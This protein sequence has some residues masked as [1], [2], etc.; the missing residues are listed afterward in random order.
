MTQQNN[1]TN[2]NAQSFE[3]LKNLRTA[4]LKNATDFQQTISE[5]K[6]RLDNIT[7]SISA[8]RSQYE[9]E[10]ANKQYLEMQQ[11]EEQANASVEASPVSD[12][13][14]P[15]QISADTPEIKAPESVAAVKAEEKVVEKVVE[16]VQPTND[17]EPVKK[18]EPKKVTVKVE[19]KTQV[20][21]KP[22]AP[23]ATVEKQ[24][25]TKT[26]ATNNT[27]KPAANTSSVANAQATSPNATSAPQQKT[28]TDD[29]GNI[30]VRRFLEPTPRPAPRPVQQPNNN[31]YNNNGQRPPYQGS[32]AA[33][34]TS[35]R[36]DY[37]RTRPPYQ[38]NANGAPRRPYD[39]DADNST[40]RPTGTKPPIKKTFA[41]PAVLPSTT[42]EK[43][44]GNKNKT[45]EKA[46]DKKAQNKRS[47]ITKAY[48]GLDEEDERMIARRPRPTKKQDV[49]FEP[50]IKKIEKATVN[51]QEVPIKVFSEK[52]GV[53]VTEIIKQLFK[54]GI[55]KTIN[56]SIDYEYAAFIASN[57]K[58]ELEL[59][60]DKTAED[61]VTANVDDDNLPD[62]TKRPPI[63]TVMG[64]VD[65]GKT[66]LLDA[67]RKAHVT[68]GEAGGITQHIGAYMV[69]IKNE[70]ITFIDTPGHAAFTAMRARGAKVTDVAIIVVAADDGVMPQTIEAINHAKAAE[71]SIIVAI[72]KMDKTDTNPERVKQQLAEL[73]LVPEE[74]GGDTIMVP[75]SAKTKMGIDTLL[76]SV[77]LVTEIKELKANPKKKGS[78]TVIEASLDKGRGPVATILVRNGT[79]RVGDN[80]IAGVATGK[81]RAMFDDK[82]KKVK[83]AKP[84]Y[85]VEVLG[86][87]EVPNAG[88]FMYVAD[89]KLVKKMAEERKTKVKIE[90][91]KATPAVSLGDIFG[92][93]SEGQLKS[94]NLIIKTDVQG[95]LE[96]LKLSLTKIG[97]EEVKINAI[98]GGVGAI[99]E[100]DVM[101]ARASDAIIIGFNVRADANAKTVA[102]RE[103]VDI[104]TYN[105]IYDA[106]DDVTKAMKGMLEP[107]FKETILGQV[108]VRDVFRIT[109]VGSVAG[110]YVNSGK[111]TRSSK[112]R[113]YRNDVVVF[114]G[115]VA[116]LKRFKDDAKEV[117]AGFECGVS[118][119]NY[120]DIKVDDVFEPYIMEEIQQ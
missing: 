65:H 31:R 29:K 99:N 116:A 89:E 80:V 30:K 81:I 92:R 27:A 120:N 79:L 76:E 72:N 86:F 3:N 83:E 1:N 101:L 71:V 17:A 4:T 114:D 39:K 41:T 25:Q 40:N 102:E 77:L 22:V 82:G 87:N 15:E 20:E 118:I 107:K 106:V 73:G 5:A 19:P 13:T 96:A 108:T 53:S 45:H 112:V 119:E 88:D 6:T 10:L 113:I 95:S 38:N 117:V 9:I 90:T 48:S 28:Y 104:R 32:N 42:R 59:K 103:G 51:S 18:A 105:V 56:D 75:V 94:L 64:H 93:I 26:V 24:P 111:I 70:L 58:I 67:I 63:V 85:P 110:C 7:K 54:E 52:I 98:H 62:D 68:S 33:G 8:K 55:I 23:K 44:F 69:S 21:A 37:N 46:D 115:Q 100:T 12:K 61:I 43:Q 91:T 50:I 2:D 14:A 84:S 78:G 35:A 11:Q 66:S 16:K 36:P 34:G 109:G 97:N 57:Y 49:K 60:I 74:W 47:L